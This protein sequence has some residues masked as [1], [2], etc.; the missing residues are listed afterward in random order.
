[1]RCWFRRKLTWGSLSQVVYY[2]VRF[3]L[4]WLEFYDLHDLSRDPLCVFIHVCFWRERVVSRERELCWE[5]EEKDFI[6]Y[7]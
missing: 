6:V 4:R 3:Q 7:E 2:F 1:M 5:F